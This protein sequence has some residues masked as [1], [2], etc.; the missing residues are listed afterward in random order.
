[1][2]N[3]MKKTLALLLSLVFVLSLLPARSVSAEETGDETA[4][5]EASAAY[6]PWGHG[7]RFVD[8]LNWDSTTDPYAEELV[9]SVPLQERNETYA[10]TQANPDLSDKAQ[11]Y[12][13]S[14]SNYRSTDVNEAPWNANM[15]YDEFSY[16]VFK[17]WQYADYTGAGGRPTAGIAPGSQYKEYGT[18]AIPMAAATNAAHKN[19]VLSIAEY[20]TPRA[21]QYADEM[22]QKAEDGSFPYADKLLE[23]MNYYGFDGYFINQEEAVPQEYVPLMKEFMQYMMDGGAYIQWYDSMT[24]SG[25]ISYQNIFNSVNSDF[26]QDPELGRVS[27]S[28]FLNYWYRTDA[29]K[30]SAAH[31]E[32]LGL[33]PYETVFMGVEG[34]EWRYGIDLEDFWDIMYSH[35]RYAGNLMQEDGQPYTS[36]AIWGSDFYREQYNKTDNDRYKVEYQWEAEE[37]ERMYFTSPSELVGNYETEG[38]DRSDVGIT[39]EDASEDLSKLK[40]QLNFKGLSR[41]IVEK[42]VIN[43]SVFATDFNNGHGMQYYVNGEVSRDMEWTNLNLQDILPTWQWWIES[44]DDNLLDMDWDYGPEFTRVQ[45]PFPYTQIGAYN[46]GSSLVIYGD[47]AASQYVNL[48]KTKLDVTANT[49]LSLTYNKPSDDAA[50]VAVTVIFEDDDTVYTLPI[51]TTTGGWKTATVDLG[52]YAGKTVAAIGLEISAESK[53]EGFQINLG[54]LVYTDGG[55][56]TPGTPANV[57]LAKRFDE[58]GEIQ[59]TW[60][61]AD[62]DTVK[63]YHVYAVYGDGSMKFVGGA[64]AANYYIQTLEDEDNVVALEVRSVG[65]DGS[66]SN[67]ARVA[68]A[69]G[70]RVSD[71]RTV[72]TDNKLTV[73]WTDPSEDF[74]SVE[75]SLVYWY[76]T[77]EAPEAVTVAKGAETAAL[78]IDVEDGTQFVLS[79]TTV[80]ADGTKNEP[81]DY[82]GE[83][84]D[85]YSDPYEGEAR[86]QADG[87]FDLTA[88]VNSDWYSLELNIN[89]TIRTY[90][91][92]TSSDKLQNISVPDTGVASMIITVT[93][94]DGNVSAPAT[95]LFFDG[96]ELAMDGTYGA[97]LIPDATLRS[98]L[99]KQVG[100]TIQDLV[101]FTGTLDLTNTNVKDLSGLN[102]LTGLTVLDLTH[103]AIDVLAS[104]TIPTSVTKIVI[105]DCDYL[106][107]I[108]LND[109]PGTALELGNLPKLVTLRAFGYGNHELDLSG[110]PELKD[111]FLTGTQMEKVD[112]TA[113]TKLELFLINDSQIKNIVSADA[114]AYSHAYYWVWTNAK[115]DL[116]DG[117]AEG[118]LFNGMKKYFAETELEERMADEVTSLY[119]YTGNYTNNGD[120]NPDF[121]MDL[122]WIHELTEVV[123]TNVY[124]NVNPKNYFNRYN[125]LQASVSVSDDGE[126]W[127]KVADYVEEGWTL[128]GYADFTNI[129]IELP[130]HTRGR[131]VK[132][133]TVDVNDGTNLYY[134]GVVL[135]NGYPYTTNVGTNGYFIDYTGFYYEGQQPAMERDP[136]ETLKVG[137]DGETYQVLDLLDAYYATTRTVSSGTNARAIEGADWIDADYI[138]EQAYM[139]AG[140]RVTITAPDGTVYTYPEDTL[141]AT[142][143]TKLEVTNIYTHGQNNGEEGDKLFD[144]K[145]STKWCG[146]DSGAMWLVFELVDGEKVLSEWYTLHAGSESTSFIAAAF[147]LQTL[148]TEVVTEEEYL[149]MDEAGKRAVAADPS[150]WIDLSVVTGN[151]ENEVTREVAMENLVSAQ[152]YRF[153]VDESGQPGAQTWGA[154]RIYEMELYAFEGTL[155]T[156]GNGLLEA[157]VP[158]V[159]EISYCVNKQEINS[160]RAIVSDTAKAYTDIGTSWAADDIWYVTASGLFKGVEEGVFAPKTTMTRGM[161]VTILYRLAGEPEVTGTASFKDVPENKFYTDAVIW[162]AENEI[163]KGYPDGTFRPYDDVTREEFVTFL[164]RYDGENPVEEDYLAGYPDAD[165]VSKFAKDA[166][167]WAVANGFI[168]GAI[169]NG[170]IMIVPGATAKREEAAAIVTRYMTAK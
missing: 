37:R 122:G 129:T 150:K 144:G 34:G 28:I 168:N 8:V 19:G 133:S 57:A 114:T 132:F 32:S 140:V 54:R 102:L 113:N 80:N 66:E 103:T 152:V 166:M 145:T 81:V 51:E 21:P 68:L 97:S 76:S 138:T 17:F 83:L 157:K 169:V 20:F 70:N 143:D 147:R 89:G 101:D 156:V 55:D 84:A 35:N 135:R 48:Y 126:T 146:S 139:P 165:Q 79:V 106:T 22:L 12:A 47:V 90:G 53:A 93:D 125:V 92:F 45:G 104:S 117:T 60:D 142:E 121:I 24:N 128:E 62:Y 137:A 14:S 4:T 30:N 40:T 61:L 33:D 87:L 88:P 67:G 155:D 11:L 18:I 78:D 119:R 167:N 163:T 42:S 39:N 149:A 154:L 74:A 59:L 13:I 159:Y 98:E 111:L 148:N 6:E 50:A 108:E 52:A 124:N 63:N 130:E 120:T 136:I 25:S 29:I 161:V 41:Y 86:L 26:V 164:Y 100:P 162:A 82:F 134:D 75:V 64:Y 7:Y 118:K 141:G 36:L 58:T 69:S 95:K 27:N 1:M 46:G 91:R 127:T 153:V 151:S 3:Y 94:M 49:K 105:D 71:I 116:T 23:I 72:S 110:C 31:A 15:S 16:N 9:A 96:V 158:G 115:L 43:G 56:Y 123:W 112:I 5:G 10:A 44:N 85:H 170:E 38:L 107:S 65:V 99:R 2:K 73:T 160:T 77:K 109:R 131:Y